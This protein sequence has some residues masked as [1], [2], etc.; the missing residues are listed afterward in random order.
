MTDVFDTF[1]RTV[2]TR[3]RPSS[4]T[5]SR[6][7]E[8]KAIMRKGYTMTAAAG[9]MGVTRLTLYRW[10]RVHPDFC[11]ALGLAK[12]LRVLRWERE[13]LSATDAARVRACIA[14]LRIDESYRRNN[15][16]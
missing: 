10:A 12:G 9:M 16:A 7:D 15:R 14:A 11:Y 2:S 6:C 3:G 4:Y 13:L 5:P 1:E 8:I